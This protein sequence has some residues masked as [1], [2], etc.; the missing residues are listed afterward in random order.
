MDVKSC[1]LLWKKN[2]NYT[3]LKIKWPQ[4]IWN[5][6]EASGQLRILYTEELTDFYRSPC[7]V[8]VE[9]LQGSHGLETY[10]G[11]GSEEMQAEALVGKPLI[12]CPLGRPRREDNT[13]MDLKLWRWEMNGSSSSGSLVLAM[14]NSGLCYQRIMCIMWIK[15]TGVGMSWYYNATLMKS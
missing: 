7:I 5:R 4:N 14:P 12:N 15:E 9:K 10:L 13:E 1:L 3:C 8:R 6:D 2:V 11:W